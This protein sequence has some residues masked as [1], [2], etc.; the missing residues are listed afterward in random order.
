[1][2]FQNIFK[3]HI[4]F[5]LKQVKSQEEK[6]LNKFFLRRSSVSKLID[7][8]LLMANISQLKLLIEFGDSQK[9]YY[10]LLALVAVSII[11]Q[12]VFAFVE[13]VISKMNKCVSCLQN[14]QPE[15]HRY[16]ETGGAN[17]ETYIVIDSSKTTKD[18][19]CEK[20]KAHL[21]MASNIMVLLIIFSNAF[22]TGFGLN[23]NP[24]NN[25]NN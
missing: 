6:N 25:S 18:C 20:K 10:P 19:L 15:N 5:C 13:L 14:S 22:I 16:G 12:I 24:N 4:Y 8:A 7:V 17:S 23:S 3:L 11:L 21:M 9:L 2:L 1:M